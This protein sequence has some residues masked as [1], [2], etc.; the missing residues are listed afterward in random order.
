MPPLREREK[1]GAHEFDLYTCG[2]LLILAPM[3]ALSPG[4]GTFLYLNSVAEALAGVPVN[5][6]ARGLNG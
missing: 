6:P 5:P 1:P 3:A 2:L 4:R